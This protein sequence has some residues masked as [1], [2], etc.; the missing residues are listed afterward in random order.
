M[1]R[2]GSPPKCEAPRASDAELVHFALNLEYLEAEFFL[3]GAFGKGLRSF[4]PYL[5]QDGPPPIGCMRANLEPPAQQFIEEFGFEEI[6]H[7]R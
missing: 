4:A 6:G 1:A 3:C 7:L 2:H 5:A